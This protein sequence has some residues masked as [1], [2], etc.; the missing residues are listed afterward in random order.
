SPP[1]AF[2]TGRLVGSDAGITYG[3]EPYLRRLPSGRFRMGALVEVSQYPEGVFETALAGTI[4]YSDEPV[5]TWIAANWASVGREDPQ[6]PGCYPVD[7]ARGSLF[8]AGAFYRYDEAMGDSRIRA[9]IDSWLKE[10]PAFL[11]L[12]G[13]GGG[14][15]IFNPNSD[16][17]YPTFYGLSADGN[18]ALALTD[19]T[20]AFKPTG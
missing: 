11:P 10:Y 5:V 12:T 17:C 8:D 20:Y 14:G 3:S 2:P 1:L 9:I 13:F 18:V 7:A 16:G 6:R 15:A 4:F 19:F